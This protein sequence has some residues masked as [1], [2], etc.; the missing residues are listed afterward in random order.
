MNRKGQAMIESVLILSLVTGSVLFLL[1]YGLQLQ[2]EILVDEL[3][4]E[5]LV[6]NL[7]KKDFCVIHLKQKLTELNYQSVTV[8]DKSQAQTAR[9]LVRLTSNQNMNTTLESELS[10]DL[11]VN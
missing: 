9:L 4:E 2:N 11:T 8:T 1:R 6:C 10:L 3:L 7:Q 5:T